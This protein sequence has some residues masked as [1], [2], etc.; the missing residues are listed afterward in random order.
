M[1][2][3]FTSVPV[4]QILLAFTVII[5]TLL[6]T[7]TLKKVKF[8][9]GIIS[10]KGCA[11]KEIQSD[12][13][14][15]QGALSSVAETQVDAYLKLEK[16]LAI[17]QRYFNEQGIDPKLVTYQPIFT[18]I[19]YKQNGQGHATNDIESYTLNQDFTL[20]S[21]DIS[22]ISAVSQ[23]ITTL[24]KEGLSIQS[25]APQ[26]F[27]LKIDE[28]KIMMLGQA[29]K[30]ARQRAVELVTKSG[31]RVGVLRSAH[32]GVFQITP[33]F[34]NSVSDYGEYDTSSVDKRIKAV[35]TMEYAID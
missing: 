10:V 8:G 32:Q 30:D 21:P 22:L 20:S 31:S 24:I 29:A 18:T 11:E 13:V 19:N 7:T 6:V 25:F 1:D 28:L 3:R 33:V 5:C 12:F 16:D 9:Q 34:S 15:W 23:N 17:L 4:G 2:K 27:Y 14:K 35:V 26:Y